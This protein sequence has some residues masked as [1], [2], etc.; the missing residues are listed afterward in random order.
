METNS[1]GNCD[2]QRVCQYHESLDT[3]ILEA[4]AQTDAIIRQQQEERARDCEFY[5]EGKG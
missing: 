5:K 2:R 4:T 3:F 1:C